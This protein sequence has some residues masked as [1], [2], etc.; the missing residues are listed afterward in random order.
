[1][2]VHS[3]RVRR[4]SCPSFTPKWLHRVRTPVSASQGRSRALQK[5]S[6]RAQRRVR[7]S[8]AWRSRISL[9]PWTSSPP[10]PSMPAPHPHTH[11]RQP[12]SIICCPPGPRHPNPLHACPP[13]LP[14]Y[15]VSQP[16]DMISCL[17]WEVTT[18]VHSAAYLAWQ[19]GVIGKRNDD[20][21]IRVG[22][23]VLPTT[24]S[25]KAQGDDS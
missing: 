2:Q 20:C 7:G 21:G 4:P 13:P 25:M 18:Q 3:V 14:T 17:G 9:S 19:A 15:H 10:S 22:I 16:F 6:A 24:P 5:N 1:M 8:R 23:P 11:F 12:F